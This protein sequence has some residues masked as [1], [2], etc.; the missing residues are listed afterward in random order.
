MHLYLAAELRHDELF[1]RGGRFE[2]DRLEENM[3]SV[4]YCSRLFVSNGRGTS[5]SFRALPTPEADAAEPCDEQ[6]GG[7]DPSRAVRNVTRSHGERLAHPVPKRSLRESAVSTAP[8]P[9][10]R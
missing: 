6:R 10:S 4:E 5:S 1:P 7:L 9:G 2:S 3:K 8:R